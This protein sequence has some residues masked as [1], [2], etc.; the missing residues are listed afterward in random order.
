M[1]YNYLLLLLVACTLYINPVQAQYAVNHTSPF[2][3]V[4]ARGEKVMV[5]VDG[6][7]YETLAID[8]IP[9]SLA[10]E[11]CRYNYKDNW[12]KYFSEELVMVMQKLNKPLHKNVA[13]ELLVN[14]Q[15]ITKQATVTTDKY[16]SV[17]HYNEEHHQYAVQS[18]GKSNTTQTQQLS[19]NKP[20][21]SGSAKIEFL[22][23]G[24]KAKEGK[25]VMFIEDHGR[26][27][28]IVTDKEDIDGPNAITTVIWKDNKTTEIDH[29]NK[30]W[31]TYTDRAL[32]TEPLIAGYGTEAQRKE[33]GYTAQ[34]EHVL[35]GKTCSIYEHVSTHLSYW[36]WKGFVLRVIY[37]PDGA[38]GY[39]KIA[40]AV[41]ENISIP[42][43]ITNIPGDYKKL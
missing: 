12:L 41:Y 29:K 34:G 38:E 13:L 2:S 28:V 36:V 27:V 24:T 31:K 35:A 15:R 5:L 16:Q 4:T 20:Y 32:V 30:T 14:G 11:Y 40:T 21:G 8:G 25:E 23:T 39:Q 6:S 42:A 3:A 18:A 17:K 22:Y 37:K 33:A 9:S 1:K 43:S 19:K 7:W 10:I 26:T